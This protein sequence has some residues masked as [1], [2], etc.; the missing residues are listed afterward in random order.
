MSAPVIDTKRPPW[1]L[2]SKKTAKFMRLMF[3]AFVVV[4]NAWV[5]KGQSSTSTDGT[6]NFA[7]QVNPID[8]GSPGFPFVNHDPISSGNNV[9]V[10]LF[11]APVGSTTYE[12]VSG[13]PVGFL[14]GAK[15]GFWDA[16]S[17]PVVTT[18]GLAGDSQVMVIAVVGGGIIVDAW[19]NGAVSG[20]SSPILITTGNAGSPPTPPASISSLASFYA[21]QAIPEPTT[22]IYDVLGLGLILLR[23]GRG[24]LGV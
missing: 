17:E 7:S 6:I 14:S 22:F 15:A 21:A 13:V 9:F 16:S 20:R 12:P 1:E 8:Y 19:G 4:G 5:A 23:R 18:P 3:L 24:G 2:S 11:W 10:Q